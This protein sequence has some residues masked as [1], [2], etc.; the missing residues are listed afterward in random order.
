MSLRSRRHRRAAIAAGAGVALVFAGLGLDLSG[1]R[2]NT[3]D[4]MPIGLYLVAPVSGALRRGMIVTVCLPKGAA[5]QLGLARRYVMRGPC[6]S[7]TAPLLKPVA[8]IADDIVHVGASGITVN[9]SPIPNSAALA[10]DAAGRPLQRVPDGVYRVPDGEVWLISS[11]SADSWDSRYLG[12][13]AITDIC[14]IAR[15][16]WVFH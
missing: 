9:G 7:G 16:V 1:L 11:Y 13:V 2:A 14:G 6:A 12:P 10:R 15:P 5:A 8:A 4:S 3:T